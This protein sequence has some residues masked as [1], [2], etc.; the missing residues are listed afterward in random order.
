MSVKTR[1]EFTGEQ[2]LGK[3]SLDN[4]NTALKATGITSKLEKIHP[5][6][7]YLWNKT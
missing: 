3:L 6:Y 1:I 7:V 2:T 5:V 4:V